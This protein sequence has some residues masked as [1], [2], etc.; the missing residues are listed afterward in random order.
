LPA[1]AR[2][3]QCVPVTPIQWSPEAFP[4]SGIIVAD[5]AAIEIITGANAIFSLALG[6]FGPALATRLVA[7]GEIIRLS[8]EIIRLWYR[9]RAPWITYYLEKGNQE[10]VFVAILSA[11]EGVAVDIFAALA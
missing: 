3:C 1:S 9:Q 11:P 8:R 4:R 7:S 10:V 6:G 5:E 2:H